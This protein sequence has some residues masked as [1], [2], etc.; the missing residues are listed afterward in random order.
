MKYILLL[1]TC[2]AFFQ[3]SAQNVENLKLKIDVHLDTAIFRNDSTGISS[4]N[5][6]GT[7]CNVLYTDRYWHVEDLNN[8]GLLDAIHNG[9]CLPYSETIIYLNDSNEFKQ[10]YRGPGTIKAI[11]EIDGEKHIFIFKPSFGCDYDNKIT[12]LIVK[13]DTVEHT[14]TFYFHQDIYLNG[15]LLYIKAKATGDLRTN[16]RLFNKV[17][18]DR[19]TGDTIT[20]NIIAK[21]NETPCIILDEYDEWYLITISSYKFTGWILKDGVEYKKKNKREKAKKEDD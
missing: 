6:G 5:V 8:D 4:M 7:G 13:K 12:E 16:R 3:L 1:I 2:F 9:P 10:V 14:K 20:G 18:Y 15:N 19:C 11:K 17:H 21:L